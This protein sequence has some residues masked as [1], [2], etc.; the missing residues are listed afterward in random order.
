[1]TE[2]LLTCSHP[3]GWKQVTWPQLSAREAGKCNFQMG[4]YTLDKNSV[5]SIIKRKMGKWMVAVCY[6]YRR[7][8]LK[9]PCNTESGVSGRLYPFSL[10]PGIEISSNKL[11]ELWS[12]FLMSQPCCADRYIRMTDKGWWLLNT[13]NIQPLP[14]LLLCS[15]KRLQLVVWLPTTHLPWEKKVLTDRG[16][17]RNLVHWEFL[18]PPGKLSNWPSDL[19][20]H[21]SWVLP[22]WVSTSK[23]VQ[24]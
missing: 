10:V 1:M 19:Y 11:Q 12:C 20:I 2:T 17:R 13:Q 3:I 9:Q 18:T 22:M 5:A 23:S 7:E 15:S 16:L 14:A 4:V 24:L 8:G 21:V 6:M